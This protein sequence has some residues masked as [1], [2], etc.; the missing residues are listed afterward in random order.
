MWRV[1]KAQRSSNPISSAPSRW[2]VIF[3]FTIHTDLIDILG[4]TILR[5]VDR[6]TKFSATD[7]PAEQTVNALWN[8]HM[9]VWV[10]IQIVH[11][12]EMHCNQ[13]TKFQSRRWEGLCPIS[14]TEFTP[15]EIEEHNFLARSGRCP[16]V[17]LQHLKQRAQ[18]LSIHWQRV[19]SSTTSES[20]QWSCLTVRNCPESV[21]VWCASY[22][23]IVIEVRSKDSERK[24]ESN[25][26]RSKSICKS[27]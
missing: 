18:R 15:S 21:S 1:P 8:T 2:K 5:N 12:P 26:R 6:K 13:G 27:R 23:S 11:P 20:L 16:Q 4:D 22:T 19:W 3:N 7:F 9:Q 24:S 25:R 10:L 17:S 14:G